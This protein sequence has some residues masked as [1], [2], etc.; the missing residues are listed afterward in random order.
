MSKP[1][2]SLLTLVVKESTTMCATSTSLAAIKNGCDRLVFVDLT[3]SLKDRFDKEFTTLKGTLTKNNV[4]GDDPLL[5]LVDSTFEV[6]EHNVIVRF[7]RRA[8]C[9]F[10]NLFGSKKEPVVCDVRIAIAPKPA[11]LHGA[12]PA[13]RPEAASASTLARAAPT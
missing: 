7:F 6:E 1:T 4:K 11:P 8:T 9:W 12:G 10:S 13:S 2:R 3:H 5:R